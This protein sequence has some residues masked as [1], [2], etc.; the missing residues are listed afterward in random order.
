MEVKIGGIAT[1]NSPDRLTVSGIGSC[2]VIILYDPKLR[3]G[4]VAHA[5]LPS[6]LKAHNHTPTSSVT[7]ETKDTKY[8]DIAIDEMLKIMEVQGA[9]KHDLEAKLVGGANMF[10][11]FESDI[12]RK[13]ILKAKEKLKKEGIKVVGESV[14]GSQGRSVEFSTVSGLVMVKMKF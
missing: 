3:V 5:M 13:N 9:K 10:S 11:A 2:L 12:G 4:T 1:A 8:V 7:G 6:N 14:G